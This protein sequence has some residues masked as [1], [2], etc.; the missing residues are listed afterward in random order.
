M[1][2]PAH[3]TPT[4]PAPR[5]VR[6]ALV[7]ATLAVTALLASALPL[8]GFGILVALALAALDLL[9]LD[10]TGWLA[11]RR[12]P[13]LDERQRSLRDLAHRRGFRLAMVAIVLMWV[14]WFATAI[15]V[16]IA[17]ATTSTYSIPASSSVDNGIP[18]RI[19]LA[20]AELLLMLPTLV[21]AWRADGGAVGDG[22]EG[23][24]WSDPRRRWTPWLLLP[25]LA[26]TWLAANA[27]LPLQSAPYAALSESS[28]GPPNTAC[29]EFGGGTMVGSEFGATVGLRAN[30][31]WDGTDAYVLGYR[32]LPIPTEAL[33]NFGASAPQNWIL[34]SLSACGVDNTADF[35]AI[36]QTVCTERIDT[37]GTLHYS[38]TAR[39]SPLPFGIAARTVSVD[40]VVTRNGRVLEQP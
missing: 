12:S 38:V 14:V 10:A 23:D 20:L 1:S 25:V 9:L 26:A 8:H 18:G 40:L 7:M 29:R 22:F 5:T 34:M 27:W 37:A 39:V 35:A 19:V 16:T 13:S 17:T 28:G 21:I 24:Q 2:G 33:R 30:V 4:R 36:S 11:F 32:N 15:A 3:A 6:C 31:C